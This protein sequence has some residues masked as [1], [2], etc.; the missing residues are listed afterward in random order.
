MNEGRWRTVSLKNQ[1][2]IL[3]SGQQRH[4]LQISSNIPSILRPCS[5]VFTVFPPVGIVALSAVAAQK[6]VNIN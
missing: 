4:V 1:I 3:C 5:R 2:F 6:K